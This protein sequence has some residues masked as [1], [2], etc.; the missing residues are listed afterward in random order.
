MLEKVVLVGIMGFFD[1]GGLLQA[2]VNMGVV[3]FFLLVI[4]RRMPSKTE[5]Y[6]AGNIFSHVNIMARPPRPLAPVARSGGVSSTGSLA[7]MASG[8]A[9]R[10]VLFLGY[11]R[12]SS[13]C[14]DRSQNVGCVTR[15]WQHQSRFAALMLHVRIDD[16]TDTGIND[17][18]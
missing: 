9:G 16:G 13:S 11:D 17:G 2:A 6:N 10:R 7:W 4:V 15:A 5:E 3:M 18:I 1:R 12:R 8:S 14:W